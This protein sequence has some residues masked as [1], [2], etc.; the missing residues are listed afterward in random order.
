MMR[1][2]A[3]LVFLLACKS[4]QPLAPG[5]V[6]V[7]TWAS[8]SKT[9]AATPTEATLTVPCITAR[10]GPIQLDDTLGFRSVGVVVGVTGLITLHPGDPYT[11]V[12]RAAGSDLMISQDTLTP[13]TGG[14]HVCNA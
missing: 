3:F 11:L 10:F 13:G 12:G 4:S 14:I 1:A 9:L 8:A 5:A 2:A 7:G 6:L